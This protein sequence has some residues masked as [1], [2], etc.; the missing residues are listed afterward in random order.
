MDR[1]EAAMSQLTATVADAA[2]RLTAPAQHAPAAPI[3]AEEFLNE[4][5]A[6]PQGVIQREATLAFQRAADATLNPAVLRVLE[7]GSQQLLERHQEQV[8]SRFGEGT[9][10]ELYRPQLDKDMAQLRLANPGATAD[11]ATVAAL[12]DRVSGANV[13]VLMERR[14]GLEGTARNKGMSHLLPSGGIPRLRASKNLQEEIPD[15]AEQF[16]LD[17][18]KATGEQ[19]D[20]KAYTKLYHT[21]K[22]SGPGRHRTS[23]LDFLKATG[24]NADTL[25]MY[26]GDRSGT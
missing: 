12:V 21:G 1:L 7:T 5:S 24:A 8:D 17:V 3:P 2:N 18:E 9:F 15:D 10:A 26:G 4:L 6:N 19:I 22:E 16:L 23:V 13:E 14:R 20:R 11:P 25:K